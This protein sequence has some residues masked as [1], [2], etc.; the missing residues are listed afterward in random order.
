MSM[1]GPDVRGPARTNLAGGF[2]FALGA[3]IASRIMVYALGYAAQLVLRVEGSVV[4]IFCRWDCSWYAAITRDGYP[5]TAPETLSG[6]VNWAFFP[7]LPLLA[8]IV[9]MLAPIGPELALLITSNLA[10]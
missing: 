7:L 2:V 4:E 3:A 8:R 1:V 9:W 6:E 5:T 10:F